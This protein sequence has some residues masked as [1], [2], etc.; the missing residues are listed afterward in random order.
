M[1]L[2]NRTLQLVYRIAEEAIV[3]VALILAFTDNAEHIGRTFLYYTN[4]SV[5]LAFVAVTAQLVLT[6]IPFIR[7]ERTGAVEEP[8]AIVLKFCA[9]ITV[10]ATFIVGGFVLGQ[11]AD[12]VGHLFRHLF[13]P[14][15]V[16]FDTVLFMQRRSLKVFYPLISVIPSLLY[17][18]II[19]IRALIA[20]G[21]TA[22]AEAEWANYYP[23]NFTNFDNGH[24]VGGLV[25]MLAGILVGL[26]LIAY[27]FYAL[28]KLHKEN[29]KLTFKN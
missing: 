15:I 1:R 2:K 26:L 25:G 7:G 27:L 4:W 20:R 3:L 21:G 18:A 19:V 8:W 9:D 24:S 10:I 11:F 16:V 17:W 14:L 29:G 5:I 28:D 12:T 23:Y 22:I 13:V 6:A